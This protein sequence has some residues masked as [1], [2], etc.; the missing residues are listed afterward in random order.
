MR[1]LFITILFAVA[2]VLNAAAAY[3]LTATQVTVTDATTDKDN[4]FVVVNAHTSSGEYEVGFDVWP[5]KHSVIGAFSTADKTIAY[6]T[7]W[8]HKTKA[9]DKNVNMWYYPEM[10]AV[11]TLTIAVKNASTCTLSGSIQATRNEVTYT[12]DIA[13]F[14]FAYSETEVPD[15]EPVDPYRFEPATATTIN[16]VAD[17]VNFK[18]KDGIINITLNEMANET[19]D[20]VELNL[21]SDELAW[22]AGTY[23]ISDKGTANTLTAS[24]GYV[25]V[26]NDD[27]CYVAIRAD[28]DNWGQYTPYYLISGSLTVAY[29]TKTDSIFVTGQ[30]KSKNGTTVNINVRSQNMLYVEGDEPKQPEKVTLTIDTVLITYMREDADKAAKKHPYTFNFFS[31]KDDYPNVIVDAVLSDSMKLVAG[32]YTMAANQLSGITLFQNQSDFNEF[33]FGGQPYV[34][35]TV[36]LTLKDA[37]N[38]K[39]TYSM[40]ITDEIGSEY[41]FSFTQAPHIINYPEDNP[42]EL[43][44]EDQPFAD[45]Q[46]TK[47]TITAALDSIIWKDE[48]VTKDGILDIFLFQRTMDVNG[49][50]AAMQLGMFTTVSQVPA[51]TYPINGSEEDNTFSASVGRYGNILF[52]CYLTLVDKDN[53]V[54]AIWY[55]ES[56]SITVAYDAKGNVMLS[57]ECTTHFGSS[58]HFTYK[59]AGEGIEN[60]ANGQQQNANSRKVLRDGHIYI[61]RGDKLYNLTGKEIQ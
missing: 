16:F 24:K 36:S 1:K 56:G 32:T 39:W 8:V 47:V 19:Y 15:P 60:T 49:L 61:L 30:A 12:Y 54:H 25:G 53:W 13:A 11:I 34:F 4:F 20:W 46:Q 9:N 50:R 21:I 2:A 55:I 57:G 17:V 43:N 44:P 28:K 51:G 37:G 52:P 35:K 41:S 38:G 48:T 27:P 58:I 23:T 40:F 42:E 45:E 5:A 59:N 22:P 3:N 31:S 10:D 33:F 14:D 18:Q 6:Y 29:N 26:Q 7:S